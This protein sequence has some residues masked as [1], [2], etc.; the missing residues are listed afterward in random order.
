M[1]VIF[2]SG[3]TG[4]SRTLDVS[5]RHLALGG[6]G[7]LLLLLC[8]SS[9]L[10]WAAW[11]TGLADRLAPSKEGQALSR[12]EK[13]REAF[14]QENLQALAARVGQIEAGLANLDDTGERL[15]EKLGIRHESAKKAGREADPQGGPYV[16]L[17]AGNTPG[18]AELHASVSRL[19]SI[20]AR[21]SGLFSNLSEKAYQQELKE[22]SEPVFFPVK[23][24]ARLGS[25]FGPRIDPFGRGRA[26]HE[27]L[28]FSAPYGTPIL[29]AA[30]GI[31][32][33]AGYHHDF[34]NMVE[35]NHAG[36]WI[37]RYA[38]MSGL[39]VKAGQPVK[40]GDV[41]GFLGGTGRATGPHLHLEVRKDGKAVD[42]L[43]FLRRA[44]HG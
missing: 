21:L 8:L 22:A 29:A 5:R 37:T 43:P 32:A 3:R 40:Q 41:I 17:L 39:N 20:E 34:G 42:P 35:I 13:K 2:L 18:A 1:R 19:E 16:P 15:A 6:A 14:V 36:Q 9:G 11:A 27:G 33:F 7:I 23:G 38:H 31:V 44:S 26:M 25:P 24:G 30:D 4:A 10:A 12:E 28:D